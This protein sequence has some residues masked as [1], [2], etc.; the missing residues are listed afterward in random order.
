MVGSMAFSAQ[1]GRYH[2]Y[3][4]KGCPFCYRGLIILRFLD[5]DRVVSSPSWMM[6]A[7]EGA[8]RFTLD[9]AP[10]WSMGFRFLSEAKRRSAPQALAVQRRMRAS[11]E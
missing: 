7:M 8:G 6:S 1:A 10:V 11:R 4:S 5:L 9:T 2:L 3:L